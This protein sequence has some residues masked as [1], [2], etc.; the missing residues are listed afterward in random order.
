[1]EIR[2]PGLIQLFCLNE[3]CK[4]MRKSIA[5]IFMTKIAIENG[6]EKRNIKKGKENE[7]S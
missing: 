2:R 1:M 7:K 4:L 3:K 6:T 5:E